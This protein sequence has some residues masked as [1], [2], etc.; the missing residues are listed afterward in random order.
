MVVTLHSLTHFL[1]LSIEIL[2]KKI[3]V[4]LINFWL[5]TEDRVWKWQ[6]FPGIMLFWCQ[7]KK[8]KRFKK[9]LLFSRRFFQ[10]ILNSKPISA[11]TKRN[12]ELDSICFFFRVKELEIFF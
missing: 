9:F 8:Q 12:I 4:C 1:V 3:S 2:Q 10:D 5:S 6:G 11:I 7:H